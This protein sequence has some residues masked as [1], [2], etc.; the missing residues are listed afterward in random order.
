[1][2]VIQLKYLGANITFKQTLI[3]SPEQKL[4][5][6]QVSSGPDQLE[7]ELLESPEMQEQIKQMI[8]SHWDNWFTTSIPA[9][10][11][12]TPRAAAKTKAGREMLEALLLQYERHDLER[13]NNLLKVDTNYLRAEL[14]LS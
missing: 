11:N 12:K 13:S 10:G 5:S 7:Q 14:G 9:L 2:G 4:R 6:L 3:E 1:M 8:Q